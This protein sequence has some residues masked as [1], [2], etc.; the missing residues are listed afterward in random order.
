MAKINSGLQGFP[1][2]QAMTESAL[3]RLQ[4]DFDSRWIWEALLDWAHAEIESASAEYLLSDTRPRAYG[5]CPATE[6][7]PTLGLSRQDPV[8]AT[9]GCGGALK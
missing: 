1:R 3:K 4:D 8:T 2:T 7:N 5:P 9:S 6:V